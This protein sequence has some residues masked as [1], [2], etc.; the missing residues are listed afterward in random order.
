MPFDRSRYPPGWEEFSRYVRFERAGNRCEWCDAE[1]Y[2]PHP[3]TGS[4]VVLTV[5]HLDYKGG[6]CD[7]EQLTG[8]K[9]ANKGHVRSLCQRCHLRIDIRR[10]VFNARRTRARRAGQLW[11]GDLEAR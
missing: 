7:C 9:C 2:Q 6:V 5:A 8:R 10:H 3:V 1:N 11:L 4:R